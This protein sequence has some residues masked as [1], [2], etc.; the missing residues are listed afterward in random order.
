M[1]SRTSCNESQSCITGSPEVGKNPLRAWISFCTKRYKI[2]AFITF[3]AYFIADILPILLAY[4][5]FEIVF[6]YV[7]IVM[8]GNG[9]F[10]IAICVSMGIVTSAVLFG[11]LHKD[12]SS[13]FV[14]SLPFRRTEIFRST[15]ISG[16]ILVIMPI[17]INAAVFLLM[18]GASFSAGIE[19]ESSMWEGLAEAEA[20][21]SMHNVFN[22]T[23]R[24]LVMIFFSYSVSTLAAVVSGTTAI[25]ILLS[26]LMNFLPTVVVLIFNEAMHLF[27][28]GYSHRSPHLSYLTPYAYSYSRGAYSIV[29]VLP[30][31]SIYVLIS[32]CLVISARMVYKSL[33]L[34]KAEESI[35]FPRLGEQLVVLVSVVSVSTVVVVITSMMEVPKPIYVIVVAL[36]ASAT[37]VPVFC[38][39]KDQ[40]FNIFNRKNIRTAGIYTVIMLIMILL[41][42]FDVTGYEKKVPNVDE[43]DSV[44]IKSDVFFDEGKKTVSKTETISKVIALQKSLIDEEFSHNDND[45]LS[46]WSFDISYNLKNG[47]KISRSYN[48][49][50]PGSYNEYE[51]LFNDDEIKK[52]NVIDDEKRERI[53]SKKLEMTIMPSSG[54]H[55]Y[56]VPLNLVDGMI[57]AINEDVIKGTCNNLDIVADVNGDTSSDEIYVVYLTNIDKKQDRA[58]SYGYKEQ[59]AYIR[60]T[61][62][63]IN[64]IKFIKDNNQIFDKKNIK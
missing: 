50:Y 35:V 45:N 61:T 41:S 53:N 8:K 57:T 55:E 49:I 6:Q 10:D 31:L 37:F 48:E 18:H 40:T 54:E 44:T 32:M 63:D 29:S 7:Q 26:V 13:T 33:N 15:F 51:E 21:L 43:V 34:E 38:M 59:E 11:Y 16:M 28:Y 23:V 60:V 20:I 36:I 14:H 39:V 64:I 4:N 25:Q 62:N 47:K 9:P 42:V 24:N 2:I 3:L 12:S 1:T 52:M 46:S 27:L 30:I 19:R 22:W 58:N 56:I 5:R 17:V